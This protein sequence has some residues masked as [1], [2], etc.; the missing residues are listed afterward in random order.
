ML[1]VYRT[2]RLQT[3]S[4]QPK[5]GDRTGPIPPD[6]I[7]SVPSDLPIEP[8]GAARHRRSSMT[9]L[10]VFTRRAPRCEVGPKRS[11]RCG[12]TPPISTEN[13]PVT[14]VTH[15]SGKRTLAQLR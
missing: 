11:N 13:R 14:P 1:L 15:A 8:R 12:G 10:W 2:G 6:L 9:Q 5:G 7:R 3:L 4:A